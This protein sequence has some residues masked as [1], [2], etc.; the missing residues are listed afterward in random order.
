MALVLFKNGS[1]FRI[2]LF[3]MMVGCLWQR[4]NKLRECQPSWQ[5]HEIGDIAKELVHEFMEELRGPVQRRLVCWSPL[6]VACYKGNFDATLFDGSN[7]AG[8][9]VVF[10]DPSGTVIAALSK[11]IGSTHLIEMA[12]ALAARRAV[13]LANQLSLFDGIIEGDC[14]RVTQALNCSGRRLCY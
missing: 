11:K 6:L 12:E 8:I 1:D 7:C 13:V 3:A 14:L 2:A 10:W 4:Q 5:L 9:R